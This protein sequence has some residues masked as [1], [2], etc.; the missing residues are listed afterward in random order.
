MIHICEGF[1]EDFQN[2][3]KDDLYRVVFDDE[4]QRY[5][6]QRF[7]QTGC[8]RGYFATQKTYSDEPFWIHKAISDFKYGHWRTENMESKDYIH[9]E[10]MEREK[11]NQDSQSRVREAG[12]EMAK[13]IYNY[14]L[15]PRVTSIVGVNPTRLQEV[16]A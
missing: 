16:D 1:T 13:D 3:L 10:K 11:V 5:E 8:D 15:H 4:T 7:R 2:A 9:E 14:T 12:Q 6:I